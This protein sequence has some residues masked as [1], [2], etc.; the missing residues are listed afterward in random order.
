MDEDFDTLAV[1]RVLVMS[2]DVSDD[3]AYDLTKTM[4]EKWGDL[5][6]ADVALKKIEV[7]GVVTDFGVTFHPGVTRYYKERGW[8]K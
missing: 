1:A 7:K 5:E 6:L 3:L 4:V 8:M 2:K